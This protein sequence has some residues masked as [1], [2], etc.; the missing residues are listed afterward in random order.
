M[1]YG[2]D[3]IA[4]AH[5]YRQEREVKGGRATGHRTGARRTHESGKLALKGRNLRPLRDPA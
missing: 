3:F 2:D 4:R 1:A 5:A